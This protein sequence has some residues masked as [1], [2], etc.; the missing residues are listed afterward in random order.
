MSRSTNIQEITREQLN[1][2]KEKFELVQGDRRAFFDTYETTKKNNEE[3]LA[4]LRRKNKGLREELGAAQKSAK[5]AQLRRTTGRDAAKV[6]AH[7][8][9][10]RTQHD[11]YRHKAQSLAK[12]YKKL[13]DELQVLTRE[14]TA[15]TRDNPQSRRIRQ[16]ENRLDKAMIKF[17][18]A[19]SIRKTYDQIVRRLREERVGFDTQLSAIERSLKAKQADLE[20]LQQL[21]QEA[22]HAKDVALAELD[23]TK[24]L[25][26]DEKEKRLRALR[27]KRGM[28][29][30]RAKVTRSLREREAKRNDRVMALHGDMDS[31]AEAK[32][33]ENVKTQRE[34]EAALQEEAA[35]ARRRVERHEAAFQRIREAT[36]VRDENEVIQKI[37]AQKEQH[38]SLQ[39][40]TRDNAARL[41]ELHAEQAELKGHLDAL[42][43][44]GGDGRAGSR[45]LIDSLDAQLKA[46]TKG[47]AAAKDR[48]DRVTRALV[49]LRAGALHLKDKVSGLRR[50][51]AL[52][53][54][55]PAPLP[56]SSVPAASRSAQSSQSGSGVDA[57]EAGDGDAA[58]ATSEPAVTALE[59]AEG[60]LVASLDYLRRFTAQQDR[61]AQQEAEED[62]EEDGA[63][64][65]RRRTLQVPS[66][67]AQALGYAG[68]ATGNAAAG[69]GSGL[70][71]QLGL[72]DEEVAVL[73]ENNLRV[74]VQPAKPARR[75]TLV[76]TKL[77]ASG[78][79][80]EGTDGSGGAPAQATDEDEAQKEQELVGAVDGDAGVAGGRD[81]D[82]DDDDEDGMTS[83][84]AH[85]QEADDDDAADEYGGSSDAFEQDVQSH[86]QVKRES[87]QAI[88]AHMH[89]TKRRSRGMINTEPPRYLE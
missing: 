51:Q 47:L 44:A 68:G 1:A 40:L 26:L 30:T 58:A 61:I 86:R 6:S 48:H 9:T 19:Q 33:Q 46:S 54:I 13:R 45:Q 56:R 27:E 39:Q 52:M 10:V 82:D 83:E 76:K 81:D 23:K 80:Q 87:E 15:Q 73:R 43:F 4:E 22:N 42:K 59:E 88:R 31:E 57:D 84:Q 79:E 17:N 72:A 67:V 11:S 55:E 65:A 77:F 66:A 20:E 35:A 71:S 25:A 38:H 12:Q 69:L 62:E 32:L 7:L 63:P 5:E 21:A 70:A 64:Q 34:E 50:E 29:E 3:L 36:G 74:G 75:R 85:D 78:P 16:L 2:L 14:E 49:E 8:R 28:V 18:E 60:V 89:E 41:E 37:V 24:A 53:G